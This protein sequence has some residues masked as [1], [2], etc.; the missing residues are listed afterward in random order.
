MMPGRSGVTDVWIELA[1][2]RRGLNGRL[3]LNVIVV[4]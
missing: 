4:R 1:R 2:A 3:S